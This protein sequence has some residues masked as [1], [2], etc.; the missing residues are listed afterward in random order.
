MPLT[1]TQLNVYLDEMSK[2]LGTEYNVPG[3][4]PVGEGVGTDR[5]REAIART[6][7]AHP[8]LRARVDDSAGDPYLV[9]DA[10]PPVEVSDTGEGFVRPFD[11]RECLC[12]FRIVEKGA[13][14]FILF[15]AHHSI[16]DA[17]GR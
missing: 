14:S 11:L 6:V 2:D 15:D 4:L 8:V 7:D 16:M 1:E 12:R 5:I 13:R 10:V 17:T 3:I 9:T